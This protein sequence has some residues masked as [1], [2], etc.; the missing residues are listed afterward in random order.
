MCPAPLAS[1]ELS[2]LLERAKDGETFP[3]AT[4]DAVAETASLEETTRGD[5][6]TALF[7][8][9]LAR[10]RQYRSLLEHY[11]DAEATDEPMLARTAILGLA[12][13]W[14]EPERY[15]DYVVGAVDGYE[16]DDLEDVRI[17]AISI[18]GDYL[19]DH[20]NPELLRKVIDIAR[21]EPRG[22]GT[23]PAALT[24]L[25]RSMG[26]TWPEIIQRER[27]PDYG[28]KLIAEAEARLAGSS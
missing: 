21:T 27:D 14:N 18:A 20:D 15:L 6:Y 22:E 4:I 3:S 1:A 7:I 10:A 17:V 19:K 8:L 11:L 16:W 5:R 2:A 9:G 23:R 24:A 13:Y 28:S 12:R 26:L 25:A